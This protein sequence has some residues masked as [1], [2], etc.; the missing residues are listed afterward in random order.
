MK[1][2]A[3]VNQKGGVA[4]TTST[5]NLSVLAAQTGKRVLMID[6]DPQASLTLSSGL[7]PGKQEHTICDLLMR[8][9]D[10]YECGYPIPALESR[11]IDN[12]YLIPSS[13]ELA[14]VEQALTGKVAREQILHR[15]LAAFEEEFDE[16]YIDCPP[17]LGILTLNALTSTTVDGGVIIP[18]KADYLSY[19]GLQSLRRTMQT[20]RENLNAA[21]V[22]RGF[23]ITMYE[24]VV[25]DQQD[26]L[27]QYQK[28][29]TVLGIVKKSADT[30]RSILDG[31]PVV[32]SDPKSDVS[33]SY[34]EI[35]DK[36]Q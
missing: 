5:Y 25:R 10:P 28:A 29:G 1:I 18:A 23:I 34:K 33:V 35:A 12:L 6:L 30:Y 36:I 11:G 9:T 15:Q 20:V 26:M 22:E 4:K 16:V 3:L 17:E 19:A 8:N 13:I 14:E 32:I 31:I 24:K 27:A 7:M 2:F 21:L